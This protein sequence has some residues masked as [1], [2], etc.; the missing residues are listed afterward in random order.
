MRVLCGHPITTYE[1]TIPTPLY[2]CECIMMQ[3]QL[4]GY[5]PARCHFLAFLLQ[6]SLFV[7]SFALTS[8]G[9]LMLCFLLF[10]VLASR[11]SLLRPV[12]G[13]STTLFQINCCPRRRTLCFV[14][15]SVSAFVINQ[16]QL[17]A[18]LLAPYCTTLRLIP[19]I[20][21]STWHPQTPGLRALD[22][23]SRLQQCT[24]PPFSYPIYT[25]HHASKPSRNL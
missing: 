7:Q 4:C 13:L 17:L 2:H 1:I 5:R 6:S 3:R 8:A 24:L 16:A 15:V 23:T 21:K 11:L 12:F 25:A 22:C 9:R 18:E 19:G 10:L 20:S 14:G